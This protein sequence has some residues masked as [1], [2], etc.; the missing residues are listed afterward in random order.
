M[1]PIQFSSLLVY[2]EIKDHEK[3]DSE[4]QISNY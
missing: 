3:K 2:H 1:N 4:D